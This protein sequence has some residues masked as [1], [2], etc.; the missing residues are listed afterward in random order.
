MRHTPSNAVPAETITAEV[1]GQRFLAHMRDL[2]S[3]S[4]KYLGELMQN[5]RRAGASAVHFEVADNTLTVVDDGI[6]VGDFKA[7]IHVA[8]S[9]WDAATQAAEQPFGIGFCAVVFAAREVLV[10]SRGKRVVLNAEEVIGK[11]AIPVVASEFIGAGTRVTLAGVKSDAGRLTSA[12]T[13]LAYGFPIPVF[14]NGEELRRPHAIDQLTTLQDTAVGKLHLPGMSVE[15]PVLI[16]DGHTYCQG[17]PITVG[18]Y[19]VRLASDR[20]ASAVLHINHQRYRP[21]LP[22]RDSIIDADQAAKDVVGVIHGLWKS[23][24]TTQKARMSHEAF[25]ETFWRITTR[26][27]PEILE[28]VNVIPGTAAAVITDNPQGSQYK[29]DSFME[30]GTPVTRKQLESGEIVL[31][32]KPIAALDGDNWLKWTVAR[33]LGWRMA[34]GS[35]PSLHWAAAHI[36]EL[37]DIEFNL[38]KT[39]TTQANFAGAGASGTI[40][41]CETL[42]AGFELNGEVRVVPLSYSVVVGSSE[43]E[44]DFY[45]LR[46]DDDPGFLLRQASGYIF[47]DRFDENALDEDESSVKSLVAVLAGEN[48]AD[49]LEKVLKNGPQY[50]NLAGQSF[51]VR[52]DDSGMI[53]SVVPA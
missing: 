11:A 4:T 9:G 15:Q 16:T 23:F 44:V 31:C 33:Q 24:L 27:A 28:D 17:L 3:S 30:A 14:V 21:R 43:W 32:S 45:V 42:E 18:G 53:A 40:H 13:R 39:G 26:V 36:V 46:T 50:N 35:I 25:V 1:D 29:Y 22:D 51:V 34:S 38:V 19:T 10:E 2:F 41:L 48:P 7:L 47:D 52:F 49:T 20:A 5:A 12:I 37:D 6:G 8:V